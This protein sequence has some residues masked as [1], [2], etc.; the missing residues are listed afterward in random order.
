MVFDDFIFFFLG[1]S[2]SLPSRVFLALGIGWISFKGYKIIIDTLIS[3]F[4]T[5]YHAIPVALFKLLSLAGFT[6]GFG[7][8]LGAFAAKSAIYGVKTLG[9]LSS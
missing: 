2:A 7:L 1:L 9:A 3:E 8:V 5:N 6:D 4:L